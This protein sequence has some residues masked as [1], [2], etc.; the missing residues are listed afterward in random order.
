MSERRIKIGNYNPEGVTIQISG[1]SV[2]LSPMSI[3]TLKVSN[4]EHMICVCSPEGKVVNAMTFGL[5]AASGIIFK[6]TKMA[7]FA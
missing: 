7:A 4:E 5:G 3:T 2:A 6:G 1:N